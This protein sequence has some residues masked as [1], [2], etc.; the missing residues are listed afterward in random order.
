MTSDDQKSIVIDVQMKNSEKWYALQADKVLRRCTDACRV[1]AL[2][3]GIGKGD[4]VTYK[5][6]NRNLFESL[7]PTGEHYDLNELPQPATPAP[8]IDAEKEQA[9]QPE[10]VTE[11]PKTDWQK[12]F[13]A[14]QKK[15]EGIH[16]L[17]LLNTATKI[18]EMSGQYLQDEPKDVCQ[19]VMIEAERLHDF[20]MKKVGEGK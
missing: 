16:W 4:G 19:Q 3:Y 13:D 9:K 7:I 20:I 11:A 8:I 14:E 5:L 18:V 6:T 15:N 12:K 17:A 1:A 2:K 10:P